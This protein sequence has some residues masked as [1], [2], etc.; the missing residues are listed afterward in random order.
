MFQ[1]VRAWN[2]NWMKLVVPAMTLLFPYLEKR[3]GALLQQ[4]TV[5]YLP[6]KVTLRA[7]ASR[8]Q[9]LQDTWLTLIFHLVNLKDIR[10]RPFH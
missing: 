6:V 3:G 10:I 8:C 9:D 1:S 5:T 7:A 2:P 4:R